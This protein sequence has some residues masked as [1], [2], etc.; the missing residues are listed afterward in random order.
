MMYRVRCP[1][2]IWQNMTASG[3]ETIKQDNLTKNTFFIV[4]LIGLL[5]HDF[6]FQIS[7]FSDFFIL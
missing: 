4:D 7:E 1:I 2:T 6:F 5:F 3:N